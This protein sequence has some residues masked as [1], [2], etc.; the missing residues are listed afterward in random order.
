MAQAGGLRAQPKV[1]R[2]TC[3][4]STPPPLAAAAL[5]TSFPAGLSSLQNS[6]CFWYC[7]EDSPSDPPAPQP[8]RKRCCIHHGERRSLDSAKPVGTGSEHAC[9]PVWQ[10]QPGAAA[11]VPTITTSSRAWETTERPQLGAWL[12]GFAGSRRP[13]LSHREAT[14]SSHQK[15]FWL[16]LGTNQPQRK[17]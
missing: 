14:A 17:R 1:S 13:V 10:C 12:R 6:G 15:L 3:C 16:W 7:V 9:C 4:S 11:E 8:P 5:N 2:A